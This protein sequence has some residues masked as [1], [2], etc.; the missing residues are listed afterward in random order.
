ME[1]DAP[2]L[3]GATPPPV[4]A[5][6]ANACVLGAGGE[7][8]MDR[9]ARIAAA[10]YEPSDLEWL[11]AVIARWIRVGGAVSIDRVMRVPT[12]PKKRMKARRDYWLLEAAKTLP[13]S[14]SYT[15]SHSL[16]REFEVFLTRGVWHVWRQLEEPPPEASRLRAALFHVAR[17]TGGATVSAKTIERVLRLG[18]F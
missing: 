12:T 4:S 13:T 11:S 9:L 2:N 14:S 16:A 1:V 7:S 17:A 18:Q 6:R 15:L 5:K 3:V 8:A 10:V